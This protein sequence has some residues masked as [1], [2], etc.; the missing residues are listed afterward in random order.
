MDFVV[1]HQ[2]LLPGAFLVA[3]GYAAVA[4]VSQVT[5]AVRLWGQVA[6]CRGSQEDSSR[7]VG[8]PFRTNALCTFYRPQ[9]RK[10]GTYR[11]NISI[12][13]RRSVDRQGNPAGPTAFPRTK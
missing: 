9:S 1:S 13:A 11:L 2:R 5:F 10:R 12:P 7:E 4:L 6:E 3:V 8:R